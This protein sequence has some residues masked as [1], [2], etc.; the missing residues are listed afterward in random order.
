MANGIEKLELSNLELIVSQKF[1]SSDNCW[2]ITRISIPL[3]F[4][5]MEGAIF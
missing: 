1:P 2:K 5:K 4:A 3:I